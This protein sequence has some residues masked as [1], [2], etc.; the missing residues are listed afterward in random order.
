MKRSLTVF[1]TQFNSA[2]EFMQTMDMT[3]IYVMCT[4]Y[5]QGPSIW[6]FFLTLEKWR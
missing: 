3:A 2:W 4:I 6:S 1:N 5:P